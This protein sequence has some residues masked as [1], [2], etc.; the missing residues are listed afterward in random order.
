MLT[1]R[2]KY[3]NDDRDNIFCVNT[4][5]VCSSRMRVM[6]GDDMV[7]W[8]DERIDKMMGVLIYT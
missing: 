6:V 5:G 7:V 2:D 3:H 1:S 8:D 4:V